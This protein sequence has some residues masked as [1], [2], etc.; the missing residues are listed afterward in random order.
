MAQYSGRD[1]R[2]TDDRTECAA[3]KGPRGAGS[4]HLGGDQLTQHGAGEPDGE[5]GG[6][7]ALTDGPQHEGTLRDRSEQDVSNV[8]NLD[9]D[10]PAVGAT[11][12]PEA[13]CN[14]HQ[15]PDHG[16]ATCEE[17]RGVDRV[18]DR[19]VD[20]IGDPHHHDE[21]D[22]GEQVDPIHDVVPVEFAESA[23]LTSASQL[24]QCRL[25]VGRRRHGE[26]I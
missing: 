20:R 16:R 9:R 8:G 11:A 23:T 4:L 13:K 7:E 17:I 14:D 24:L 25:R 15:Q 10:R 5:G 3:R 18:T 2:R 12:Q 22:E 6:A 21:A 19:A 26:H 1:E